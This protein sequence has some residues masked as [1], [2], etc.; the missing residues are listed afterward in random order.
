MKGVLVACGLDDIFDLEIEFM[1]CVQLSVQSILAEFHLPRLSALGSGALWL[2]WTESTKRFDQEIMEMTGISSE[3]VDLREQFL[4][5]A[6][7]SVFFK[8]KDWLV[9]WCNSEVEDAVQ[10]V[11]EIFL[12]PVAWDLSSVNGLAAFQ[13]EIWPPRFAEDIWGVFIS[14]VRKCES[15]PKDCVDIWLRRVGTAFLTDIGRRLSTNAKQVEAYQE[16]LQPKRAH[17]LCCIIGAA[18]FFVH[19]LNEW[20]EFDIQTKVAG[21]QVR[22]ICSKAISSFSSLRKEWCMKIAKQIAL[23]FN[24]D[25][26]AYKSVSSVLTQTLS[27]GLV[28]R[29][30]PILPRFLRTGQSI[31]SVRVSFRQS[32]ASEIF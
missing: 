18:N 25:L 1:R 24:T 26:A 27:C 22:G 16:I 17:E 10:Q 20:N 29:H 21:D 19:S 32:P 28:D 6:T 9:S 13:E 8:E 4:N 2:T 23:Q 14:I 30:R 12:R 31:A 3:A 15:L 5:T 11:D 7:I